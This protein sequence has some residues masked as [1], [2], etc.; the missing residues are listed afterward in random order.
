MVYIILFVVAYF[1]GNINPAI[2]ISKRTKN[3]DIRH[4]NSKNAGTSNVTMSI[5]WKWG[6]LVLILDILKGFTPVLI[7]RLIYPEQDALWFI[8]GLGAIV[9]HIYP[10]FHGFKG[11][12]GSATFGGVLFATMT[13]YGFIMLAVYILI[14][15][16]TDY[17]AL[18]TLFVS[19]FTPIYMILIDMHLYSI[20]AMSIFTVISFIK[21]A[22]NYRRI[23]KGEEV[24]I[25]KFNRNKD[26]IRVQ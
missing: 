14:L 16:V 4:I 12:K 25:R 8:T 26:K 13:V 3:V 18:S 2:I 20:L 17:I 23:L 10:V 21:H 11:G 9:G 22:E 1:V 24:G 19:V 5:G 15:Y 7:V 6:I